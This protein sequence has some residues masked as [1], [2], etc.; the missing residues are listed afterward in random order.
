MAHLDA[1]Y[2]DAAPD[3][4]GKHC[5]AGAPRSGAM[6]LAVSFKAR[7]TAINHLFVA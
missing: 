5:E 2:K 7:T 6:I 4:A 3:G 1:I